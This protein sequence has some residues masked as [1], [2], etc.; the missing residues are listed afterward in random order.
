MACGGCGRR[1]SIKETHLM[2]SC[3]AYGAAASFLRLNDVGVVLHGPRSCAYLMDSS[4][5][6]A[7]LEMYDE[8]LYGTAPARNLRCSGMD[9]AASIFGGTADLE[10]CIR[11]TA[12]EGYG[13]IAVITTCMPGIIGDDC[14]A[15]IERMSVEYSDVR[16]HYVPADGDIAGDYTDGFIMA[17]TCIAG[18]VDTSIPRGK[19]GVNLIGS[20]FFD[21]HT[22]AQRDDLR[23]VLA[24]FGLHEHARF[25]DEGPSDLIRRYNEAEFDMA[26][27]DTMATREMVDVLRGATGRS[28]ELPPLPTGIREYAEWLRAV[29]RLTGRPEAAEEEISR[30]EGSYRGFVESHRARFAGKRVMIFTRLNMNIDWLIDLLDDLG[31]EV[32]RIAFGR[33]SRKRGAAPVTRYPDRITAEYD[34][35]GFNDDLASIRPDIVITDYPRGD[36]ASWRHARIGKVGMGVAPVLRYAEY[37]E[38]LMRLPMAEGWRELG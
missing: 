29:G 23:R 35:E 13:D 27:N 5:S 25:V 20:T 10:R 11:E 30:A 9:D 26:I 14:L 24:L 4:R 38:D 19:G 16:F 15:V 2:Q 36:E 28:P 12:A 6:K 17:A 3:A 37:L 22:P 18:M 34:D 21:L 31:A 33:S 8:G 32:P 1:T 7:V